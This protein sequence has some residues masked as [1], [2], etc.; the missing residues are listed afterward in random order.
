MS[1]IKSISA[2]K[3]VILVIAM[4]C[5]IVVAVSIKAYSQNN[6]LKFDKGTSV[7]KV[8]VSGLTVKEAEKKYDDSIKNMKIVFKFGA[9]EY[10]SKVSDICTYKTDKIKNLYGEFSKFNYKY[11][12]KCKSKNYADVK[13]TMKDKQSKGYVAGTL[14]VEDTKPENAKIKYNKEKGK[15]EI[16]K[17]IIGN[18]FNYNDLV[19]KVESKLN[20]NDNYSKSLT[21]DISE[22][23]IQPEITSDN[24]RLNKAV[25]KANKFLDKKVTVKVKGKKKGVTI[26]CSKYK[27]YCK[28]RGTKVNVSYG[29]LSNIVDELAIKYNTIGTTRKFKTHRGKTIKIGGGIF[30]WQVNKD[31][32]VKDIEKTIKSD[33]DNC[34]ITWTQEGNGWGNNEIG[35]TYIEISLGEQHLY[36]FRNGKLKLDSSIV[37]GLASSAERRTNTGVGMV[38]GKRDHGYLRGSSWNTFVNWFMPFNYNGQG[39][40]DATWR[41]SF[42]GSIYKYSGS[43]GCVNMP[44]DKAGKLYKMVNNGV[45]VIVY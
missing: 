27:K 30:G 12:N 6:L 5:V 4:V 20:E 13:Y 28:V 2:K 34:N 45:P 42:G 18:T 15:Y 32:T 23:G 35:K 14:Q 29:F 41:S 7:N 44:L 1:G 17:E 26:D 25:E 19:N 33:R 24:E 21:I 16:E 9:Y 3:V 40:H 8:D 10:Y 43:H 11:I 31:E 36:Y 22:L 37:S 38:Y 39:M